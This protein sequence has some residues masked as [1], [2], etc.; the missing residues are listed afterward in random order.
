MVRD[1]SLNFRSQQRYRRSEM[2]RLQR[3]WLWIA[4]LGAS[5]TAF[6]AG[7]LAAPL[8]I[9]ELNAGAYFG[10]FVRNWERF[11]F[12]ELRGLPL[13][14]KL[15]E[16]I[17]DGFPYVHHPPALSWVFHALGG[18]EW[19]MRLPTIAATF[20]AA[21]AFYRLA[22]S[23]FGPV[24]SMFGAAV[25]A[26]LP[27]MAVHG[28]ASYEPMVVAGGLLVMAGLATPGATAK[29]SVLS[30]AA[31]AFC[32]TWFGWGF[33]FA[34]IASIALVAEMRRP[35]ATLRRLLPAG[36][37]AVIGA[38]SIVAWI[39]WA[40]RAPGVIR[41]R[42]ADSD[43][44]AMVECYVL[45]EKAGWDW[46]IQHLRIV[47]PSTLSWWGI[48][49]FCFGI[50]VA[51]WRHPR[52]AM[53][54]LVLGAAPFLALPRPADFIWLTYSTP[55]IALAGTALMSLGI[56]SV[57]RWVR[58][59]SGVAAAVGLGGVVMASWTVRAEAATPFWARLG[60]V[61]SAAAREPGWGV[62]HGFPIAF[63]Y[64]YEAPR[65]EILGLIS[66][67]Q[68]AP[69][70]DHYKGRGWKYLWLKP[71]V[72]ALLHPDMERFLEPF[73]RARV[74]ELEGPLDV[75]GTRVTGGIREAWLVTLS[76]PPK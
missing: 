46:L 36:C 68:L 1:R 9:L 47:G 58:V 38:L 14:P 17:G 25:L 19:A 67:E 45:H 52:A 22:R 32:A 40:L 50:G 6:H 37:A 44:A 24:P 26:F 20:V 30:Q 53:A 33:A 43:F 11:G 54:L 3:P 71:R 69:L 4:M 39:E 18:S 74:P 66:P 60:A 62:A 72:E 35:L 75:E 61:L 51:L 70:V 65:V 76:E 10:V 56:G 23:R 34:G 7:W 59:L 13:M 28:Q 57:L 12:W 63:P 42:S 64:Y 73:P 55:V 16:G 29:S 27:A 49:M 8:S 48:G 21:V 2:N 5:M 41:P 31:P 15:A